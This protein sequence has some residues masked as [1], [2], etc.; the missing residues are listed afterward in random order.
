MGTHKGHHVAW[1]QPSNPD[2]D[3]RPLGKSYPEHTPSGRLFSV[4]RYLC[5]ARGILIAGDPVFPLAGEV[6][7]PASPAPS[8][9]PVHGR[10][11]ANA[12]E[13]VE[14]P[15]SQEGAKAFL[16]QVTRECA[17]RKEAASPPTF[18]HPLCAATV[19]GS[20]HQPAVKNANMGLPLWSPHLTVPSARLYPPAA[21]SS[22]RP[23]PRMP[24]DARARKENTDR[25]P[26]SSARSGPAGPSTSSEGPARLLLRPPGR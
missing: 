15:R 20:K 25:Q 6:Y 8:L 2:T 13:S 9:G 3:A 17:Q 7:A 19:P 12:P 10:Y 14:T 5:L 18:A 11:S 23:A 1:P 22:S 4:S 21:P 24:P 16:P 26:P